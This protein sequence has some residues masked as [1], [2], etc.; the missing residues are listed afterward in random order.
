MQLVS[1]TRKRASQFTP[2]FL[3][4][5][6]LPALSQTFVAVRPD[7][8]IFFHFTAAGQTQPLAPNAGLDNRT[9]GCTTWSVS[10]NSSGFTAFNLVL[11]SAPNANGAP[12]TW[13]TYLNQTILIGANPIV[14]A[15]AGAAGSVYLQGYNPWVRVRLATVTGSGTVDGVAFGWSIPS[16]GSSSAATT[17]V[18]VQQWGGAAT[19]L[20]QKLM[21]SSVPVVIASDQSQVGVNLSQVGGVSTSL[22]QKAGSASI[23]VV[24][25]SDQPAVGGTCTKQAAFNLSGSGNTQII[26]ASG[27][28][29]ISI[30]HISLA[31]VSPEDIKLVQGTHVT[32]DC[33]TGA[34]DLTGLYKTVSGLALD[35]GPNTL[36]T[37][38]SQAVCINQ[39]VAQATGGLVI[40]AQQ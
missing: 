16:A 38:A 32:T 22:G 5:F 19:S 39:S 17:N 15:G 28:T 4:L 34:A 1:K 7:C 27:S 25:A 30:C 3:V 33:D 20:G 35:F 21:A 18:N 24:L 9:T 31:G 40:Y 36:N 12:G 2:A 6:S 23:P 8:Q 10:A 11:Q 26:A 14:G 13:V 29:K 37:N